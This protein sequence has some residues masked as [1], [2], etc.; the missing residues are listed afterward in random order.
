MCAKW[1][2]I[3]EGSN[4]QRAVLNIPAW[5]S[6][7]TLDAIGEGGPLFPRNKDGPTNPHPAAFGVQF[8]SI[9][10]NEHPLASKYHNMQ[11]VLSP[12]LML[13]DTVILFSGLTSSDVRLH[14]R[15]SHR[16]P[17]SMFH[18]GYWS[19]SRIMDPTPGLSACARRKR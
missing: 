14:S 1:T 9:E 6:R 2:G 15:F 4:D 13:N 16:Q 18:H 10:N 11:S 7:A 17:L 3:I 5:L 19:G 8:G 12:G